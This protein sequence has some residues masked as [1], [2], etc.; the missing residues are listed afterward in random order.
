MMTFMFGPGLPILF[1]INLLFLVMQYSFD[2]LMMAYSYRKPPMYDSALNHISLQLLMW[3]PI[4]YSLTA[5]SLYSNQNIFSNEVQP[6]IGNVINPDSDHSIWDAFTSINPGNVF[7]LELSLLIVLN[8][9]QFGFKKLNNLI[10]KVDLGEQDQKFRENLDPFF[11]VLKG[12]DKNE[13]VKEEINC[14]KRLNFKRLSEK[15]FNELYQ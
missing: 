15:N 4:F 10:T 2:R 5:M 6:K 14:T 9:G 13:W 11:T 12:K 7:A 3:A 8:F 1:P